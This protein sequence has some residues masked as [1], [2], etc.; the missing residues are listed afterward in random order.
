MNTELQSTDKPLAKVLN[1]YFGEDAVSIKKAEII[2][3]VFKTEEPLT[4]IDLSK[5]LDE[6]IKISENGHWINCST[7]EAPLQ[8]DILFQTKNGNIY[9][10]IRFM[11]SNSTNGALYKDYKKLKIRNNVVK[12]RF[13]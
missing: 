1:L 11:P 4:L 7:K 5:K 8:S 6:L 3:G 9:A 10:G 2:S 12:W 13:F